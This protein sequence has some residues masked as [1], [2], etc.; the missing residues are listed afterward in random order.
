MMKLLFSMSV[1]FVI[2]FLSCVG[3]SKL[4]LKSGNAC[5]VYVSDDDEGLKTAP[6]PPADGAASIFRNTSASKL[7]LTSPSP[8]K[9]SDL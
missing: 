5:C 7:S 9:G 1:C 8:N 3:K 2:P 4:L 6:L